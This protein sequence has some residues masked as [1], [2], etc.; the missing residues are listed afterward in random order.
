MLIAHLSDLHVRGEGPIA[1]PRLV[2]KRAT[3]YVNL[4]WRRHASHQ[5]WAVQ[6]LSRELRRLG[7]DHVAVTGDLTNLALEDEFAAARQLLDED[8]GMPADR[9]TV[10]PG[11][12]DVYTRG[13]MH[14]RRFAHYLAPYLR[15]DV[16]QASIDHAAGPFPFARLR[17]G[18]AIVGLAT[19][20]PSPPMFAYGKLGDPQLAAL[21]RLLHNPDLRD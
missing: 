12:H 5:K 16:A 19:A 10:V 11:N 1:L 17:E 18:V 14:K 4:R 15:G 3:G 20:V 7:V 13:S 2:G 8:L 9:V 6:A 21:R